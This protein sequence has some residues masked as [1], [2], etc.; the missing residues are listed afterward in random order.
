M[1]M[2]AYGYQCVNLRKFNKKYEKIAQLH[3]E[4]DQKPSIDY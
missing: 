4:A 3:P 1:H 2:H